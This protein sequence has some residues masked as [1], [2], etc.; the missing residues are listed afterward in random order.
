MKSLTK[1][2][3][4]RILKESSGSVLKSCVTIIRT[5]GLHLNFTDKAIDEIAAIAEEINN[6]DEDTGARRLIQVIDVILDDINYYAPNIF[7][8]KTQSGKFLM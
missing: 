4:V 6:Q 3:F 1:E 8:E 7:E 5:E 2:D